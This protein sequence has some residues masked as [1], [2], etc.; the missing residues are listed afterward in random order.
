MA[1]EPTDYL[2][3]ST[4]DDL[5]AWFSDHH[6]THSELWVQIFK[7]G[8]GEPSVTWDDCVIESIIWGW[9]DGIKKRLDDASYLQRLT[10]RR[11][12]SNW[13]KRNC[14][15]AEQLIALGLMMTT[16]LAHV[17]AAKADGRWDAAYAGSADMV[18]PADFLAALDANPAAKSFYATL[19][20]A[21]LF[22]IYHRLHSAK[23]PET[24][25]RRMEQMLAQL[26][27]GKRFQ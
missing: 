5:R 16:G 8:S 26:A 15:H 1:P 11:A 18:I 4:P 3:F 27:S 25:A 7:K 10:P 20:R 6:A 19:N 17:D 9:I 23:K 14:A 13:S 22:V 12:K 24:R 21:N 2:A